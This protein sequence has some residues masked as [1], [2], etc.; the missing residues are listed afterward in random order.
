MRRHRIARATAY[1][2]LFGTTLLCLANSQP[3]LRVKASH[4]L[5][6]TTTSH[7]PHTMRASAASALTFSMRL[8]RCCA[9]SSS[10]RGTS[11]ES[12]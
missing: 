6:L 5:V 11:L 12:L 4:A 7:P 2:F 10:L 8:G 9:H 3:E 1:L